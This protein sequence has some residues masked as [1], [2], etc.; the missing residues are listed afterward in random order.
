[1]RLHHGG[2]LIT[3]IIQADKGHIHKV[4]LPELLIQGLNVIFSQCINDPK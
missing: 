3:E 2:I 1:M 4:L